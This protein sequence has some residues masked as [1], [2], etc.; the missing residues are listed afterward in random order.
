MRVLVVEDEP[1]LARALQRGLMAEGYAVDLAADGLTGLEA[2]RHEGYDAVVLDIMLPG[3]SGYRIVRDDIRVEEFIQ[4]VRLCVRPV[5]CFEVTPDQ[6]LVLLCGQRFLPPDRSDSGMS[7]S[8]LVMAT[9][10][11]FDCRS[12]RS[13]SQ[14]AKPG[15]STSPTRIRR[16]TSRTPGTA[17]TAR[18]A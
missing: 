17:A 7:V 6:R 9:F 5:N 3:L 12:I 10:E 15:D 8:Y 16:N 18:T 13:E 11:A 14:A 1:R 4:D 2:A